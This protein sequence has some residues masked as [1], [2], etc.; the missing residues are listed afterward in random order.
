MLDQRLPILTKDRW[1]DYR[2]PKKS[3]TIERFDPTKKTLQKV[4]KNVRAKRPFLETKDRTEPNTERLADRMTKLLNINEQPD[5]KTISFQKPIP[6]AWKNGFKLYEEN[7]ITD[8]SLARYLAAE[9]SS[10]FVRMNQITRI[11][12]SRYKNDLI[13]Q[14]HVSDH[15]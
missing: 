3:D 15:K 6:I 14:I 10:E 13:F 1:N 11:E 4:D 9:I 5:D 8:Y 12:A 7:E 2:K